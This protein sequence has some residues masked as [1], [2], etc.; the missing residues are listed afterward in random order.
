MNNGVTVKAIRQQDGSYEQQYV[1]VCRHCR[2]K[3][4]IIISDGYA[5]KCSVC[6]GSGRV[7]IF[8]T[9]TVL[10]QPVPKLPNF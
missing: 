10:I 4:E 5:Q 7:M 3:G 1:D 6:E 2:G 9:I 8:K